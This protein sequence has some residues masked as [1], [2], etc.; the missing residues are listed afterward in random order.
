M[1]ARQTPFS[2]I[3]KSVRSK[4]L[5]TRTRKCSLGSEDCFWPCIKNFDYCSTSSSIY[6]C[7]TSLLKQTARSVHLLLSISLSSHTQQR[8]HTWESGH[9]L[10]LRQLFPPVILQ[11]EVDSKALWERSAALGARQWGLRLAPATPQGN[12]LIN[13]AGR[14]MTGLA[15]SQRVHV[16]VCVRVYT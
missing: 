4:T 11:G 13:W 10:Q 9:I 6:N 1:W 12:R 14:F 2:F 3:K 15:A 16:C 7:S 5:R 8:G